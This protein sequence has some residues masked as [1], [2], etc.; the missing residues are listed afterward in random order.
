MN[1]RLLYLARHGAAEGSEGRYIGDTDLPLSEDGRTQADRLGRLLADKPLS[2]I[3][4][5]DLRRGCETAAGVARHHPAP[6]Q[7]HPGLREISMGRWEGLTHAHV[8]ACFPEEY[9]A[10][11]Q[12]L[13]HYRPPEGESFADCAER[14]RRTVAAILAATQGNLLIIG[15]AGLNRT[16]LC[17]WSGIPLSRPFQLS[18]DPGCLNIVALTGS[19]AHVVV[20]N[21]HPGA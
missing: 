15:H 16:L 20:V 4:C 11:G 19:M 2:A 12:D 1:G 7:V 10:R 9:R 5:S 3:H 21:F 17:Q 18:Q 13:E 8:A 14:A 6:I